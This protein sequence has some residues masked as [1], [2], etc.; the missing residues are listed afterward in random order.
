MENKKCSKEKHKD[1][2]NLLL[3]KEDNKQTRGQK[4]HMNSLATV[5]M[6]VSQT[7]RTTSGKKARLE[8][9][10]IDVKLAETMKP[11]FVEQD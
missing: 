10:F 5:H 2:E 9:M 3:C 1:S 8:F 6:E 4:S 7:W 11:K